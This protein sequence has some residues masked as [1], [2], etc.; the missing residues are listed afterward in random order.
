MQDD[1]RERERE[2]E[3]ENGEGK[4]GAYRSHLSVVDASRLSA[5]VNGY[6]RSTYGAVGLVTSIHTI[7]YETIRPSSTLLPTA[8][9]VY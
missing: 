3:K 8:C 6:A 4:Q 9:L 2:R 1:G 7:T 5:P